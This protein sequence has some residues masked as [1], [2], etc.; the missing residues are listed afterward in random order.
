MQFEAYFKA[1]EQAFAQEKEVSLYKIEEL[2]TQWSDI[3]D[4]EN[5]FVE[6]VKEMM[7]V[8]RLLSKSHLQILRTKEECV[9][10][11]LKNAQLR[12]HVRQLENEIFR[13]L[14]YSHTQVPSTE[15]IMSLDR[16][17]FKAPHHSNKSEAD[18]EH[19]EEITK[20]HKV[21][22]DLMDLQKK[23]FKE[24]M[25][26]YEQDQ[27]QWEKFSQSVQN[28]SNA[29]HN[30][31]DN[32]MGQIV[33]GYSSLSREHEELVKKDNDLIA[34]LDKKISKLNNKSNNLLQTL[35]AKKDNDKK[36]ATK[37]ASKITKEMQRRVKSIEQKNSDI[38]EDLQEENESLQD[39]EDFL[40]DDIDD[41]KAKMKKLEEE[42]TELSAQGEARIKKLE[43]ELNAIVS[44]ASAIENAAPDQHVA[45]VNAVAAAVGTHGEVATQSERVIDELDILQ[46]KFEA[47]HAGLLGYKPRAH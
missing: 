31:I 8:K 24:E 20:L 15:Y 38:I 37:I 42:N 27:K 40:L 30:L 10:M 6:K 23:V 39:T 43:G 25:N 36:K 1:T 12:F 47:E 45:I 5:A 44:A 21:W 34:E 33:R 46:K 14:P 41:L 3:Q 4:M 32:M 13:L 19:I 26:H 18:A 7:D 35:Q 2:K 11:Q 17:V 28:S 16:D 22:V 9:Q 29:T